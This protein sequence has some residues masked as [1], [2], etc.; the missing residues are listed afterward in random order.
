MSGIRR[1]PSIG[2]RSTFRSVRSCESRN[3]VVRSALTSVAMPFIFSL[4]QRRYVPKLA[5]PATVLADSK[6]DRVLSPILELGA[7]GDLDFL[8]A[9][10]ESPPWTSF[11]RLMHHSA[12]CIRADTAIM[13]GDPSFLKDEVS[14]AFCFFLP[15]RA[16]SHFSC[17]LLFHRVAS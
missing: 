10:H 11:S 3:A 15:H 17:A 5:N 1:R 14:L 16:Y 9:G 4:S 2:S 13:G 12:N 6:V 8:I 7:G